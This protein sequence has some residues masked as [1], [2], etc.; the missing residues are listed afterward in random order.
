M[1]RSE[2]C[3]ELPPDLIAQQPTER[4]SDARLML[5]NR[6]EQSISHHQV[7]DLPQLLKSD[8][9][10]VRNIAK[11]SRRKMTVQTANGGRLELTLIELLP[12]VIGVP[13]DRETTG[14]ASWHC[15]VR[16]RAKSGQ[17][18]TLPDG[19]VGQLLKLTDDQP[20]LW[21]LTTS[22]PLE[23]SVLDE[24]A[25]VMLPPYV[26]QAVPE[27][28]YQTVYASVS[29]SLAAPTAGLHFTPELLTALQAKGIELADIVLDVGLGT[30]LP[31]LTE[32]LRQH[33]MHHERYAVPGATATAVNAARLAGRRIVAIGTTTVRALEASTRGGQLQAGASSTDLFILPGFPFQLTDVL[34]TNFHLPGSTLLALTMAFAGVDLIRTAYAEAIKQ[35]YRFFSFGDAMLI[36]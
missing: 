34:M 2:L 6:S 14:G 16:G 28:R 30:F 32:E 31:V 33:V 25:E 29:G 27:T 4:R 8:D 35:R 26:K 17:S 36:I 9:L 10:L 19:Q 23:Q 5:V 13:S 1:K 22:T 12:T 20:P 3:F 7:A 15:F 24:M 21:Q 18:I 11:V